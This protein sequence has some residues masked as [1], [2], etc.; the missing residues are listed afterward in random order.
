MKCLRLLAILAAVALHLSLVPRS[1]FG[2][3]AGSGRIV[4]HI[5]GVAVD[6]VAGPHI[7]GWACQQGRPESL[8]VH[9]YTNE[10]PL[11]RPTESSLSPAKPISM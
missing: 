6:P 2:Q 11:T 7:K 4:G 8:T 10:G 9:I 1:A 5:D 3:K